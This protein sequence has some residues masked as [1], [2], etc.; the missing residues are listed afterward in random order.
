[1]TLKNNN[2]SNDNNPKKLE[3]YFMRLHISNSIWIAAGK[4]ARVK[5]DPLDKS[6]RIIGM[7]GFSSGDND[8]AVI[9]ANTTYMI[10]KNIGS[11]SAYAN[12][13]DTY[14]DV[15]AVPYR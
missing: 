12:T 11:K 10:L 14:I 13:D 9:S 7:V 3:I 4:T 15:A 2:T 5:L 6:A 8:L 1:M